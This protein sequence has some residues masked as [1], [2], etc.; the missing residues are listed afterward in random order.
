MKKTPLLLALA[1]LCLP[2][3]LPGQRVASVNAYLPLTFTA[4][5]SDASYFFDDWQL[6]APVLG[7]TWLSS[8]GRFHELM[9]YELRVGEK[10]EGPLQGT[11]SSVIP[12]FQRERTAVQLYLLRDLGLWLSRNDH[13]SAHM[14]LGFGPFLRTLHYQP[15]FS[16]DFPRREWRI[17]LEAILMPRLRHSLSANWTVELSGLIP[18]AHLLYLNERIDNPILTPRQ[19]TMETFVFN[20]FVGRYAIQLGVRYYCYPGG[21]D[22]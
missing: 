7:Y 9:L 8:R 20:S 3:L 21:D 11:G 13:W 5:T 6:G 18:V 17:G 2:A 10:E 4:A 15:N 16:N 1:L 12:S 14:G 19:R 22:R